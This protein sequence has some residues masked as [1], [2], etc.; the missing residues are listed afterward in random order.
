MRTRRIPEWRLPFMESEVEARM[1]GAG[2]AARLA[3]GRA[4]AEPC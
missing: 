2:A 3:E 1:S 4:R